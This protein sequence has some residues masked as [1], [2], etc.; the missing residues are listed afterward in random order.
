MTKLS[1]LLWHKRA[2]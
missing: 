1:G 2:L